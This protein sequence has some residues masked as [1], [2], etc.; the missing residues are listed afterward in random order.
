MPKLHLVM[1]GRVSDPQTLDFLDL[2]KMDLVGVY[3][4]YD[5]AEDA[6]RARAQRTVDDAQMKYVIV[7][8]HKLLEPDLHGA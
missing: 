6:W 7:H 1:G 3:A 4:S 5:E 8:L 2:E